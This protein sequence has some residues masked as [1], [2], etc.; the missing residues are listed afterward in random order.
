MDLTKK[1]EIIKLL[2]KDAETSYNSRNLSKVIGISHPGSFKILKE[3]EKNGI[4]KSKQV[5]KANIYSLNFDN[6]IACKE[7]E[8]ALTIESQN[9]R[10]WIEEFREFENKSHFVI[11]FGSIL[12]DEKS[13]RDV[14]IL[15]V[16]DKSNFNKIRNIVR[17][18]DN[19]LNKKVHLILQLLEDFK[20][21][22]HNHNK[23]IIEIIKNGIVLFGQDKI[24]QMLESLK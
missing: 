15:V 4:V 7:I 10:R 1:Q 22:V 14:D 13:A 23:V 2:F 11:L 8:M 18:K 5:G 9:Y 24:R 19:I 3:L 16:A 20:N 6:P 21:D 12:R 17:E